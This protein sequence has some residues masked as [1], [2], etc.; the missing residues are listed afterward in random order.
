MH[1]CSTPSSEEN[2]HVNG[3]AHR[4]WAGHRLNDDLSKTEMG[5]IPCSYTLNH[6]YLDIVQRVMMMK[7]YQVMDGVCLQSQNRLKL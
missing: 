3:S 4:V 2:N 5:F 1:N 7:R 6:P